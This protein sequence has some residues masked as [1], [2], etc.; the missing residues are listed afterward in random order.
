MGQL[1]ADGSG[2]SR[3]L[4]VDDDPGSLRLLEMAFAESGASVETLVATD[5]GEALE[6]LHRRGD[7][8]DVRRP[9][10]VVLDLDLP[11]VGGRE[12]LREIRQ[13]DRLRP[14]PV[15]VLSQHD[16]PEIVEEC[17]RIGANAYLVK[18]DDY[19]GLLEAVTAVTAFWEVAETEFSSS[20]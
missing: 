13:T 2:A 10:I 7:H 6:I 14:L 18:P 19:D 17:Y 4:L 8:T 15:V 20:S 1:R 16:D 3:V 12:V 11:G 9:D 5:G